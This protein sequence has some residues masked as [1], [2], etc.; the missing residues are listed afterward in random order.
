MSIKIRVIPFLQNG[1][2]HFT[3]FAYF[4]FMVYV[5]MLELIQVA[6][7]ASKHKFLKAGFLAY[8]LNISEIDVKPR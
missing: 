1:Q 6:R 5:K 2:T 8:I 3:G 4:V 7:L